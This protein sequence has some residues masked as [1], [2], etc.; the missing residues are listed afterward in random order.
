MKQVAHQA[1][2]YPGFCRMKRLGVVQLPPG[3]DA[4]PSQGYPSIKFIGTHLYNWLERRTVRVKCLAQEHNTMSPVRAQTRTD[5]SG[6]E[7]T[8]HK[9]T[10]PPTESNISPFMY[11]TPVL[12]IWWHIKARVSVDI[13]CFVSNKFK[14]NNN[15]IFEKKLKCYSV[16]VTKHKN[17]QTINLEFGHF[18]CCIEYF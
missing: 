2:A 18:I 1:E 16:S 10:A 14:A 4:S 8:N 13:G 9:T 17:V 12:R 11:L 6:D 3:W 5:W 15:V 7:C